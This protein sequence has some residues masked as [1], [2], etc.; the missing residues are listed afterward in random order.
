MEEAGRLLR[1]LGAAARAEGWG[2]PLAVLRERRGAMAGTGCWEGPETPSP[3][4]PA[5]GPPARGTVQTSE[6]G[7]QHMHTLIWHKHV[8]ALTF[9]HAHT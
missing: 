5:P 8:T 2:R 3:P 7:P 1:A 9:T 6:L 4:P